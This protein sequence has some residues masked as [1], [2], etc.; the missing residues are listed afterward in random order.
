MEDQKKKKKKVNR[1]V[2]LN[3]NFVSH[4]NRGDGEWVSLQVPGNCSLQHL[5][6]LQSPIRE[7]SYTSQHTAV[8]AGLLYKSNLCIFSP[9]CKSMYL[10]NG[11]EEPPNE[12]GKLV[13]CGPL[14][15]TPSTLKLF[16]RITKFFLKILFN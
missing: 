10:I 14:S 1:Q 4:Q 15:S 6:V 12:R 16:P 13:F 7:Q 8:S 5:L 3:T 11:L 2:T 9:M